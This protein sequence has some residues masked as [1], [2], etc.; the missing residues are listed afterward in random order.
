MRRTAR[1]F[2]LLL[3]LLPLATLAAAWAMLSERPAVDRPVAFTPEHVARAKAILKRHD[4]RW[5]PAGVPRTLVLAEADVDLALN[6][7]ADR[8]ANA[9]TRI[10]F[11]PGRA[12][13]AVTLPVPANPLGRYLN[14]AAELREGAPLPVVES[15]RLGRLPLP[16]WLANAI[17][18]AA[19]RRALTPQG[20]LATG[21]AVRRVAIT[22]NRLVV[23][24]VWQADLPARLRA[25]LVPPEDEARLREHQARLAAVVAE[26]PR[27]SGLSLAEL[28]VPMVA[29]AAARSGS[30]D[31]V[32]E[33]RAALL[34]I[35][36]YA[37]G[38]GLETVVPAA[39]SWPRPASREV[40]LGG[41]ADLA[42]H[43]AISAAIA[44]HAG[45]PLSDAI[46]LYKEVED[47]S[48]GS[49]FSFDDL[50]AD[51]AG[52]R[53]GELATASRAS[54]TALQGRMR[55]GL[56]DAELLPPVED[57]PA[58]LQRPEFERRF[59]AVGSP[60]YRELADDI[61]RRIDALPLY[62]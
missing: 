11:R 41:R 49:G 27:R 8:H 26:L 54:A 23:T 12:L 20:Y 39:R 59:G 29:H 37:N 1:L 34:V 35:A 58:F 24:Y 21:E 42:R 17:F 47:A 51:R 6:Y 38:R 43:F 32:A 5:Q 31:P 55:A 36:F 15:L 10:A 14:V 50:A 33:N 44:A 57:L 19:L 52:T 28:M 7:L 53:F 16:G 2:L 56:G 60:A 48:G 40:L 46:G 25:G 18:E 13:L 61:E 4:P 62:H 9:S 30:G 3:L 45:V 22:E